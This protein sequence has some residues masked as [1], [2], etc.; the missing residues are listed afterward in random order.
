MAKELNVMEYKIEEK[1][2][3]DDNGALCRF[4]FATKRW[5][6]IEGRC[7]E[8]GQKSC[9]CLKAFSALAISEK[10]NE[11][12]G[13]GEIVEQGFCFCCD[14]KPTPHYKDCNGDT[15]F[16]TDH[17]FEY[18]LWTEV[19][20]VEEVFVICEEAPPTFLK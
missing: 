15:E 2:A 8:C 9:D 3:E 12:A 17:L 1:L 4:N 5:E 16:C 18:M 20:S 7:K 14:T 11:A 19:G 10:F 13:G 6:P